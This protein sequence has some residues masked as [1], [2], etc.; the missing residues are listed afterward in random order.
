MADTIEITCKECGK[1]MKAA[2]TLKGKKIRCK[3]CGGVVLVKGKLV[4]AAAVVEKP[5]AQPADDRPKSAKEKLDEEFAD[6]N[7]YDITQ[8]EEGHRCPHCANE[9]EGEDAVICLH[10]GFNTKTREW[11]KTV[12]TVGLTG[13]DWFKWLAPP[14]FCALLF[15]VFAGVVV[16]LVGFSKDLFLEYQEEWWMFGVRAMQLWGSVFC[17]ACMYGCAHFAIKRLI[18]HPKPLEKVKGS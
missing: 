5:V 12:H 18:F 13:M 4:K 17:L 1:E 8:L 7:P 10:C 6:N 15:F 2:A 9:L 11:N 3:G 16:W 14:I